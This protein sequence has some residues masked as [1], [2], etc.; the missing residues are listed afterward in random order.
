MEA[1]KGV[2]W[3]GKI[4]VELSNERLITPSGLSLVGMLL[5]KSEFVKRCN[6]ASVNP[7]CSQPQIKNGEILLTYIGLLCLGKTEFEAVKELEEDPECY[8]LSLGITRALPLAETL[9]QRM[10]G[11]RD[12]L[13]QEILRANLT[14]FKNV[15]IEPGALL[16]GFVPVDIDVSPFDNSKT[17]K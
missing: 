8:K 6:R 13:R 2:R 15:G 5:G 10:D 12:S 9:R 11:I 14:M 1:S 16:N 4:I 17:K 3:M 7:K